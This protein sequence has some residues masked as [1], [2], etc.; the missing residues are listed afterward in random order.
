M[1]GCEKMIEEILKKRE[2]EMR[3][4]ENREERDASACTRAHYVF[5]L[6]PVRLMT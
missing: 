5:A 4:A 2:F 3:L 6:A 1:G